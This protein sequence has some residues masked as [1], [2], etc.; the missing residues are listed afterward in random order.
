[1][2]KI[3]M[4]LAAVACMT[5]AVFAQNQPVALLVHGSN[6]TAFYGTNAFVDAHNAAVSGD[7]INLS[8]GTF[9]PTNI[10]KNLTI[11]GAGF[12]GGIDHMTI[13]DDD[14]HIQ[15]LAADSVNQLY[16]EGF[17]TDDELIFDSIT[18][19][20]FA[21][22]RINTVTSTNCHS[23]DVTF[24]HSRFYLNLDWSG[25]DYTVT[26]VNC[27]CAS[28]GNSNARCR[29]YNTVFQPLSGNINSSS[30]LQNCIIVSYFQQNFICDHC[31]GF[32]PDTNS[33][34]LSNYSLASGSSN[35]NV[36][37]PNTIFSTYSGNYD[38][39]S[40][41][42]LFQLT[43]TA[44]TTYLGDDSTQVGLYGGF[45]PYS[46]NLTYP[47]ISS[48]TVGHQTNAAGRLDVNVQVQQGN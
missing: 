34:A 6:T 38:D 29:M 27:F 25:S 9:V 30:T 46:T 44:A 45:Y 28:Y 41:A 14:L 19:G 2:K 39:Y 1:M 20:T 3:F 24:I 36:Q 12:T 48:M 4:L 35:Y 42:E 10:T 33:V 40:D 47:T 43:A 13:F 31:V 11:R 7:I 5:T 16:M 8:A 21:H 18:V 32:S 37:T 26:M 22:C 17:Y 15:I 23:L